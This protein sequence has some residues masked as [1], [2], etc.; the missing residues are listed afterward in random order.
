MK[1]YILRKY[2]TRQNFADSVGVDVRTVYRWINIS[3]MP[4]LKHADKIVQTCD[5]TRLELIGEILF[6][7][8][9]KL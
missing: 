2:G 4:M 7:E 3:A 9:Q 8:D 6:F 1:D 5:T